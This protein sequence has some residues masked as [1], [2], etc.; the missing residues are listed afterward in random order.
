VVTKFPLV[1]GLFAL[2]FA[3]GSLFGVRGLGA[4]VATYGGAV[5]P[6]LTD[7]LF[8]LGLAS[9]FLVVLVLYGWLLQK[10]GV[11]EAPEQRPQGEEGAQE[12]PSASGAAVH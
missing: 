8:W 7:C 5:A 9:S 12:P 6:R 10:L 4:G 2:V 11:I 3:V 1:A